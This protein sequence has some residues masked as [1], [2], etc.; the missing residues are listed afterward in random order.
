MSQ[1][2]SQLDLSG[3]SPPWSGCTLLLI[4]DHADT[5]N[6]LD[7]LLTIRGHRVLAARDCASARAAAEVALAGGERVDLII[8]DI[9]LPDGDG[10][11]LMCA[12]KIRL[13]CA[14]V[15]LTG[16]GM[17]DE[18]RRCAQAGIDRHLLKPAGVEQLDEVIGQ[19][20]RHCGPR[21]GIPQNG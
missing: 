15:A 3:V 19:L 10:V 6:A 21:A 9:T 20:A 2:T 7:R 17:R 4:E 5:L 1:H 18:I 11:G 12:L 14:A 8:G 13:G 16:S